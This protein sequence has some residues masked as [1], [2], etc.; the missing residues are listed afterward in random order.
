MS[1]RELNAKE[2]MTDVLSG[3]DDDSLMKKYRLSENG[4]AG[5]FEALVSEGLLELS[6]GRYVI[7][8][9]SINAGQ[10]VEDI[11]S[12]L[13]GCRLMKKYRLSPIG[14]QSVLRKLVDSRIVGIADLGLELY[15]RLE[16]N[17]PGDIR[18]QE[19]LRLDFEV[20]VCDVDKPDATGTVRDISETGIGT[21]GIAVE[22]DE[23]KTLMVLGDVLDQ[24]VPFACRARCRWTSSD[25]SDGRIRAGFQI[26][27]ISA[28]DRRQLRRL[29]ELVTL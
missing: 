18:E 2:V 14:L 8:S 5:L 16:A 23:I 17:M 26:I 21:N 11:H 13:T 24:V 27:Q 3:M 10:I 29:V 15:L 22:V 1:E 25:E 7:P 28:R 12:G 20:S 4:L 9:K 6:E 19:R